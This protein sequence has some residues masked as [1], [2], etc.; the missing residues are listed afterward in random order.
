[1]K[2]FM[3][4]YFYIP[5]D[6]C[7]STFDSG[8]HEFLFTKVLQDKL[9]NE[10]INNID[11]FIEAY[12]KGSLSFL[13]SKE[14][15]LECSL[16]YDFL[17]CKLHLLKTVFKIDNHFIIDDKNNITYQDWNIGVL[18]FDKK[19]EQK[20]YDLDI[21]LLSDIILKEKPLDLQNDLYFQVRKR[22]IIY[23]YQVN[24][25]QKYKENELVNLKTQ[26]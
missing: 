24:R 19:T 9:I 12:K 5:L 14:E 11:D 21:C 22:L 26:K 6:N 15:L 8:G 10:S 16:V 23:F 13:L 25:L 3:V 20:L 18:F 2:A 17:N 1:M 4:N 7:S